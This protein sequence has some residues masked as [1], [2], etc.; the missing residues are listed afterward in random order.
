MSRSRPFRAAHLGRVL[1]TAALLL[2]GPV[3]VGAQQAPAQSS[4]TESL[5]F[6]P[7]DLVGDLSAGLAHAAVRLPL[8]AL[9]GA[10]LAL[11]SAP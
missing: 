7:G 1:V 6:D 3:V 8:A 2:W 5:T 10:A 4:Q 11:P 9:L